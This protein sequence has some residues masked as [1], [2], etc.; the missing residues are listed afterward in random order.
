MSNLSEI[1]NCKKCQGKIVLI[2]SDKLGNTYCGYCG[3]K[4]DYKSYWQSRLPQMVKDLK[5][6]GIKEKDIEK[7]RKLLI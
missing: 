6:C 5:K 7:L 2:N 3:E 4:V 1:H